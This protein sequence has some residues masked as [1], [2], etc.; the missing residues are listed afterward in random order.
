MTAGAAALAALLA[1]RG[2]P[3]P[4]GPP[5]GALP[6]GSSLLTPLEAAALERVR[7]SLPQRSVPALSEPLVRAA[8]SLAARAAR[9]DPRPLSSWA[10][11]SA[12]TEAG[13]VDPAPAAVVLAARVN[14]LPESLAA[15]ARFRGGTHLGIGVVARDGVAWAVLLAS[16]RRAE[17]DPFP[18]RVSPGDTAVLRG[19]LVA[20]SSPR[21]YVATPSGT[22]REVAVHEEGGAFSAE[23]LF[24][25]PGRWRLEVGGDGP[26][27]PT[28]AA[29]LEVESGGG[30]PA[31]APP[32]ETDP[33]DPADVERRIRR[34]IDAVRA[35]QGLPPVRGSAPLDE[36]ARR[37]SAA[38][39]AAATVAHRLDGGGD[40]VSRLAAAGLAYRSARE[41][42][43]RG[44]GALD[45]HRAIVE[46]PAH[47]ANLLAPGA[48]LLGLGIARG[49]L[50][51]GQPVTYLTEILVEPR[52][53]SPASQGPSGDR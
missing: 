13:V 52:A 5:A 6:P 53:G 35:A 18:R 45:A 26:R 3:A 44:D 22:A 43:A 24:D 1:V 51:G 48:S 15:A 39:L 2:P 33:S 28:V 41:N 38:M 50:P 40:L 20:L 16:E 34:A 32:D 17:L 23:I 25:Q 21:V 12:L 30:L 29:V 42:V 10:L 36:Q 47:L 31:A 49:T 37:H 11:R 14:T 27:G 4:A 8:R 19:R 7:S 9:G 46:S